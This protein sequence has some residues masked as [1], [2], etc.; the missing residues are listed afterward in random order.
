VFCTPSF[1]LTDWLLS[2]PNLVI[3][4][5]CLKN[6]IRAASSLCSSRFF[7]TQ[8]SLPNFKAALA[9]IL[10]ILNF[11]SLVVFQNSFV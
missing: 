8:A 10:W 3:P 1:S 4:S 6:F 2:L 11:V 7:S 5:K 9:V